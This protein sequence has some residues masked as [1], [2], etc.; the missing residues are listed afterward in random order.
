LEIEGDRLGIEPYAD[1]L[2]E[3]PGQHDIYFLAWPFDTDL[4]VGFVGGDFA[5]ELTAAGAEA[6]IDF[7]VQSLVRSF[8]SD[9]AKRVGRAAMTDWGSN[10]WTRGAYAVAR[11]GFAGARMLLAQPV[12]NRIFFAGEVLGGPLMQTCAGAC[13]SGVSAANKIGVM[14]G[15]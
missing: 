1:F 9:I 5:W 13:I 15:T 4:L 2:I 10:R 7:A 12:A 6:A 11:P 3:R 8:G 14:L